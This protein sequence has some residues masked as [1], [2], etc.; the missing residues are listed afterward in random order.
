MCDVISGHVVKPGTEIRHSVRPCRQRSCQCLSADAEEEVSA[1]AEQR[2]E[3]IFKRGLMNRIKL[4]SLKRSCIC[5]QD[6]S[7]RV[8]STHVA[9]VR[10]KVRNN[11]TLGTEISVIGRFLKVFGG[12]FFH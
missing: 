8:N 9:A 12:I 4:L 7:S 10:W 5:V 1:W 6:Y 11:L 3:I 2:L